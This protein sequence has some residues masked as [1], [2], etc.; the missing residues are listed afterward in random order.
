[1]SYTIDPRARVISIPGIARRACRRHGARWATSLFLALVLLPSAGCS[2]VGVAAYKFQ[3]PL[4]VKPSYTGLKGQTVGVMAWA[5]REL[6]IEHS[7]LQLDVSQ[8]VYEKLRK[9]Q[10]AGAEELAGAKFPRTAAPDAMVRFLYDNPRY[11]TESI[12][13]MAP[14]MGVSRLIYLEIEDFST[15]SADIPELYRGSLSALLRVIEV[16]PAGQSKVAYQDRVQAV[17][18][19]NVPE[20][21]RADLGEQ[22]TYL[23]TLDAF[24][25]AVLQK[26]VT[27]EKER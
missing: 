18:P 20:E 5:D 1:M 7:A 11:D 23:G 3:G 2:L 19:P 26:L 13:E 16:D 24:T 9:S 17:W 12:P 25:T 4:V 15:H 10:K 14:R 8:G 27:Y 22:V 6:R 21:G